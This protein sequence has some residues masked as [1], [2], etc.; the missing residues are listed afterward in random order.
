MRLVLIVLF[1]IFLSTHALSA[2]KQGNL[3]V[4]EI[5]EFIKSAPKSEDYESWVKENTLTYGNYCGP[6]YGDPTFEA[7]C[8]SK[9]DCFC[10]EHDLGHSLKK[11]S[12]ADAKMISQILKG[13]PSDLY[14]NPK[15]ETFIE[16]ASLILLAGQLVG[17]NLKS[18]VS[19]AVKN[20]DLKSL[21]D[22]IDA[23][24]VFKNKIE[25]IR[26]ERAKFE[27]TSK[28]TPIRDVSK[29]FQGN[30]VYFNILGLSVG[31][32][33][34]SYERKISSR[35]TIAVPF[36]FVLS[37]LTNPTLISYFN[38]GDIGLSL[39]LEGK[40][41]IQ[42]HSFDRGLFIGLRT[43]FNFESLPTPVIS[44]NRSGQYVNILSGSIVFGASKFL[45]FGLTVSPQISLGYA[46]P[47]YISQENSQLKKEGPVFGAKLLV[48]YAW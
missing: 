18:K 46:G 17:L 32:F 16:N 1:N 2:E 9:V 22:I 44:P 34:G 24:Q 13:L 25:E 31:N 45:P 38:E 3:L 15:E 36:S 19:N 4:K 26:K 42:G 8:L 20:K 23:N 21:E 35:I 47:V 14:K 5:N 43:V 11:S 10:K 7:P 29:L 40:Y 48:G 37:P 27:V 28:V 33:S 39:G 41:Y 12:E 30:A 6:G